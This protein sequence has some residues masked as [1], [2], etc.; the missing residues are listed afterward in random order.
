MFAWSQ[1]LTRTAVSFRHLLSSTSVSEHKNLW[2][3][4]H[5]NS[6]A[7]IISQR[8]DTQDG[9]TSLVSFQNVR[10][11]PGPGLRSLECVS[12]VRPMT[13]ASLLLYTFL[14]RVSVGSQIDSTQANVE[15]R[16]GVKRCK[17]LRCKTPPIQVFPEIR[18]SLTLRVPKYHQRR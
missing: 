17:A 1:S 11:K 10:D 13:Y 12:V 2:V 15:P 8:T 9:K 18:G 3:T 6:V 4:S 16:W 7:S 5:A 14:R